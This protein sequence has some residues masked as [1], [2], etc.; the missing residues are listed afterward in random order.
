LHPLQAFPER[1]GDPARF[2]GIVCGV[3]ADGAL[4]ARLEGYVR[5][6]G[7]SVLRLEGVDRA[8]YH[9][10]AVLASNY[11]VALHAAAAQA[12]ALAGLP[13]ALA[14]TALAPLTQGALDGVQ[15]LTLENA[16]TGPVAR[17][18]VATIARHLAA[19]AAAPELCELYRRLGAALLSLPLALSAERK[20]ALHALLSSPG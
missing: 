20:T 4:G 11:V 14:R 16:L 19:L 12:F 17:G 5:A 8:R 18:D 2:S 15:R 6:L 3:E 1:F 7:A 9:A 10:A 13:A